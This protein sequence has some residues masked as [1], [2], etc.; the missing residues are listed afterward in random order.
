[1]VR[2]REKEGKA[3]AVKDEEAQEVVGRSGLDEVRRRLFRLID[4][5]P[6]G[7]RTDV[8]AA[9]SRGVR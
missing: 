3:V 7:G 9:M 1:M 2:R 8:A 5:R 6:E 4:R